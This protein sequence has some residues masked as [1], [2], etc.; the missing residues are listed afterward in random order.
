MPDGA[1][2]KQADHYS[3]MTLSKKFRNYDYGKK[4]NQLL[5]NNKEPPEYPLKN[6]E[7]PFHIIYGTRDTYFGA[8]VFADSAYKIYEVFLCIF[9][10]MPIIYTANFLPHLRTVNH[11][12]LAVSTTCSLGME[13]NCTSLMN[14][15]L[16]F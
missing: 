13:K 4:K 11:I 5:Y 3:Q 14:I 8:K 1:N 6:I 9:Y 2:F 16:D 7:V 12:T 15:F 10:R